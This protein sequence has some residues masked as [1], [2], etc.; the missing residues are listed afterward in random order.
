MACDA[1][2]RYGY[3]VRAVPRHAD[4]PSAVDLGIVTWA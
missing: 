1:P 2:G 3:T 4:L